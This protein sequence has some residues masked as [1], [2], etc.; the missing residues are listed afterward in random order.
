MEG[1]YRDGKRYSAAPLPRKE[2]FGKT[3]SRWDVIITSK[4]QMPGEK[5]SSPSRGT[6]DEDGN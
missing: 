3:L 6:Y 1:P 2:M 4:L 5:A